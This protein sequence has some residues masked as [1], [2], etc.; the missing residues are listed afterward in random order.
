MTRQRPAH[1]EFLAGPHAVYEALRA[2]RRTIHR[3]LIARQEP[4]GTV[5][6]L[7]A[8]A[9]TRLIPVEE[10]ARE[11]LDRYLPGG[12]HQGVLAETSPFP[13]A[14]PEDV[15]RQAL[16]DAGHQF[17]L[18]LDGVQDPQNLGAIIR[19]AEAA[20]ADG[21][22]LPRDR[23]TGVSPAAARAS[24]G[25]AEHLPIAQV[26]NLAMFLTHAREQGFWIVGTAA[27]TGRDL[28]ATDLTGPILLVVGGEGRGLRALTRERCDYLVRIP[29][30]GRVASLNASAAAAVCLFEVAR[31]RGVDMGASRR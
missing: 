20:G 2:G 25:A 24:A 8:L 29:L 6:P 9:R 21:L 1:R 3:I 13:Y 28:F 11:E 26:S 27:D 4:G 18:A 23:A 31:Q 22:L 17:L 16:A 7:R 12:T 19:S 15:T 30:R 14:D 10:H 5:E